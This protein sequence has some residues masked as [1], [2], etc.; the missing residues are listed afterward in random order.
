[1]FSKAKQN[2]SYYKN[3][4]LC[5]YR[6]NKQFFFL[7]FVCMGIGLLFSLKGIKESV[8]E[9]SFLSLAAAIETENFSVFTLIVSVLLI[10]L[11]FSAIIYLLSCNRYL[12]FL[13]YIGI[14]VLSEKFFRYT[15]CCILADLWKGLISTFLYA[16]PVFLWIMV[17]CVFFLCKL[18]ESIAYPCPQKFLYIVPYRCYFR[19]L[20]KVI[21]RHFLWMFLPVFLYSVLIVILF[22]LIF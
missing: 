11:L 6:K 17:C 3:E 14:I 9:G 15:I 5:S 12:L 13:S 19:S 16:L 4:L 21:L 1:M 18:W 10:P 8:E 7:A 22:F 2:F 20:K